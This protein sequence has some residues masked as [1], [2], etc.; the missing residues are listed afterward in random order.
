MIAHQFEQQ[1][2]LVGRIEVQRPRLHAHLARDLAHGDGGEPVPREK[3]QGRR[4]DLRPGDIAVTALFS[5]HGPR[6]SEHTFNSTVPPQ[7]TRH[8]WTAPSA[9]G[10]ARA[11]DARSPSA[12]LPPSCWPPAARTFRRSTRGSAPRRGPPISPNWCPSARSWPVS[13]RCPPRTPRPRARAS[14]R[15]PPPAPPRRRTARDAALGIVAARCS[16]RATR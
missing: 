10:L 5:R 13:T 7:T 11:W 16:P 3:P 14:R 1:R 15:A 2:L 6:L 8:I 9:C 12:F 4:A